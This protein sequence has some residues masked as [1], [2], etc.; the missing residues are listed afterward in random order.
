MAV[1]T[2]QIQSVLGGQSATL[3]HPNQGQF[4]SSIAVDPEVNINSALI[5]PGGTLTPTR[6]TKFS[7]SNVNAS[8]MWIKTTPK[9]DKLYV[10]LN[11]GRFISYSTGFSET[12][13]GTPT[14]GVGNGM[15]YYN[16]YMY[17]AT[18][19]DIS[20]YGPLNGS[21]SLTNNW[22]TGLGLT[23]LQNTS[24]PGIRNVTYPNHPMYVHLGKLYIGD[25]KDGQGKIHSI[26]TSKTTDEGDTNN[27]S[28]YAAFNLPFGKAPFAITNFGTD[29]CILVSEVGTSSTFRQGGC[30]LIVWD[31][32]SARAKERIP[33]PDSLATAAI[34]HGGRVKIF[35]GNLDF[36]YRVSEYLGGFT[37]NPL[38]SFIEGSPPFAG[39]VDAIGNR[40]SWGTYG[41]YPSASAG[42]MSIGYASGELPSTAVNYTH[43]IS[44]QT[45]TFPVVSALKYAEQAQYI[46]KPILGWRTD[47][48]ASYGLDRSGGSAAYGSIWRGPV[49]SVGNP[50][51]VKKV[52]IPLAASVTAGVTI[53]PKI[54]VDDETS[55]TD[56][57]AIDNTNHPGK[58]TAV[59]ETSVLGDHNFYLELSWTGT[60]GLPVALPITFTVEIHE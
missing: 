55:S 44:N 22:W 54:Y 23:A 4:L 32:F 17:L 28:T 8:P 12:L 27:G 5:K 45:D 31:T 41:T 29:L 47:T 14:S 33:L 2:F 24:Y 38:K 36:G 1:K 37:V 57:V 16:N 43:R 49:L 10:Y 26:V 52:R 21:P 53:S 18:P 19:T 59:L 51:T 60:V 15:E 46:N 40:L 11:N 35:T 58:K 34:N 48:S 30:E 7:G 25:F 20:R 3:Y 50:F 39:A 6:L 56:L 9:D 42:A 13:I